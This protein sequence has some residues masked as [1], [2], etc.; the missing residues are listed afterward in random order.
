MKPDPR[1]EW[2]FPPAR[3]RFDG[4]DLALADPADEDDRRLLISAEHTELAAAVEDDLDEIEI[5]GRTMSPRLHLLMHE[6]VAN[7]IWGDDPPE[8]WT[9]AERLTAAGF[10][11]HDVL[12][13]LGSVVAGELWHVSQGRTEVD[14]D[15]YVAA[16]DALPGAWEQ[17]D[18]ALP[19]GTIF[20]HRLTEP[21]L[22]GGFV[23]FE[24]DLDILDLFVEE[25]GHLHLAGGTAVDMDIDG[26][27]N[28]ILVGE[29][30]WLPASQPG[31]LIGFRVIGE[32]IEVVAV[33]ETS[34]PEDLVEPLRAS[35]DRLNDGDGRPVPVVELIGSLASWMPDRAAGLPPV[36]ELFAAAE[37]EARDGYAA[38]TGADWDTLADV[39]SVAGAALVHGLDHDEA[40]ALVMVAMLFRLFVDSEE[41]GEGAPDGVF[42]EVAHALS[43]SS[44]A[45]A[46]VDWA[47]SAG[48]ADALVRFADVVRAQ[49][50]KRYRA[51][52]AWVA[53]QAPIQAGRHDQAEALLRDAVVADDGFGPALE[54]TAWYASDRGDAR[55]AVDLLGHVAQLRTL[56]L[57]A[58]ARIEMLVRYSSPPRALARRNDPCPC[59]SGRKYKLCHLR[60]TDVAALT[61]RIEWIWGKLDWFLHRSGYSASIASLMFALGS[62]DSQDEELAVSLLLFRDGVVADFLRLR[63]PLL[64]VDERSLV[65]QWAAVD[66]SLYAVVAVDAGVGVMLRDV[67]SGESSRCGNGLAPH[68]WQTA[69]SCAPMS[70]PTA[71]DTG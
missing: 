30:G 35:F 17:S 66:R 7:Q 50:P 42:A 18:G 36:A 33:T 10:E 32:E 56:A 19:D 70:F 40:E 26:D 27:G 31:D 9:T 61:D 62:E 53:A 12:H 54:D 63:G 28:E 21:E 55:R 22:A 5:D 29:D 39:R 4:F 37:F 64:P 69:T 6:V 41:T 45:S 57:V 20:T 38:P 25:C 43:E 1:R 65:A 2:L 23:A 34:A 48:D 52:P 67:R 68:R 8:V 3:G 13:M 58:E 47:M 16:L 59:G 44:I 15:R 60:Q 11:R 14:P 24:P 71:M 51:G 49:A 46:F